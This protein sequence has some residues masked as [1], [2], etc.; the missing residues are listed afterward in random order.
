MPRDKEKDTIAVVFSTQPLEPTKRELLGSLARIYDPLGLASPTILAGKVLYGEV[1]DS[2]L[3][4]D[5]ALSGVA[6][7]KWNAWLT[8]LR[9]RVA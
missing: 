6:L 4:W 7:D 3:A 2:R 9:Y 8:R 5:K 1:C